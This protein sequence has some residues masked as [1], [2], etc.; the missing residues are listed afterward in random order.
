MID[1]SVVIPVYNTEKYIVEC[2]ESVVANTQAEYEILCINDGST[3]SSLELLNKLAEKY[4][5]VKVAS[6]ENAGQSA[7]RNKAIEMARGKYLYFLDSDDKIG[8]DALKNLLGYLEKEQLDVL[9]FSGSSFCDA[10]EL[11]G[12]FKWLETAYL[13]EGTYQGWC[14]GLELMQQLREQKDYSVSPC[15]QIVRREFLLEHGISFYEG[16]IHEDNLFSFQ[17]MM[18][19]ERAKC[20][21]DIY[22]YRRIR[23]SSV[24]TRPKTYENLLGYFLC[25]LNMVN[26][27]YGRELRAEDEHAVNITLRSVKANVKK[28]YLSIGKEER[29]KFYERLNTGDRL[30]FKSIILQ[31]IEIEVKQ[32][33]K[34][35]KLRKIKNSFEYKV[36]R[37]V[38]WPVTKIK[39]IIGKIRRKLHG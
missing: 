10:K 22:F 33:R 5:C 35:K 3:D 17:V 4:D 21:N 16:I 38:T 20:I 28:S 24:M 14:S 27:V 9:Y 12:R 6:Q 18:N 30:F 31:Q 13:R 37:V 26:Y 23:E 8:Q 29:E 39:K 32:T 34:I 36:G 2:V 25:F 11:E 19:A 1:I 7:A 15:T